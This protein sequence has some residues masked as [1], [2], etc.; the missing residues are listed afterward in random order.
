MKAEEVKN[1]AGK[2]DDEKLK[3][4]YAKMTDAEKKAFKAQFGERMDKFENRKD[5]QFMGDFEMK[6]MC[7]E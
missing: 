7:G 4:N 5:S 3:E 2:M 6:N 1:F